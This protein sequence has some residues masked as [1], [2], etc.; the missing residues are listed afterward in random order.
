MPTA[1]IARIMLELEAGSDPIRGL[2]EHADGRRRPFWGW[3]ELS[4]ALRRIAADEHERP[5][6]PTSAS[7][8]QA[9]EPDVQA[10]RRQP[11]TNTEE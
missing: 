8:G 5:S 2:I 6:Q 7:T 10:N 1:S 3:L 4:E 11:H 9:S